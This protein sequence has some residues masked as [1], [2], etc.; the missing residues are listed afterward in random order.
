MP[1]LFL[2]AGAWASGKTETVER[3]LGLLPTMTVFDWDLIIPG[4][5]AVSGKDVFRDPSTWNG[6]RDTWKAIVGASL[7]ARRDVLL[8]GPPTSESLVDPGEDVSVRRAYLDCPDDVLSDRL[9]ARGATGSEIADELSVAAALRA[10]SDHR[11]AVDNGGPNAV[12][13]EVVKWVE[14]KH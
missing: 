9:S 7:A 3:L 4:L 10:S 14:A 13:L 5:S 8:C 6:L 1:T 12:A 11:I 2:L